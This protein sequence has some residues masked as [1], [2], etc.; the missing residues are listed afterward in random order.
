MKWILWLGLLGG[1]AM[2]QSAQPVAPMPGPVSQGPVAVPPQ[3]AD[4]NAP[5]AL[6]PIPQPPGPATDV[7][8]PAAVAELRL[9]NK[10]DSHP[11]T[12]MLKLGQSVS[13]GS[14]TITLRACLSRPVD[15][16]QDWAAY[17][18]IID[19]HQDES[20]FHGWTLANEPWIGLFEHPVYDV[21]LM[22]CH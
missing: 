3:S 10:V 14:L 13:Y 17:L 15:Q 9:M 20:G 19:S 6:P 5:P 7:W 12:V 18:D 16:I 2:A 8:Q 1:W 21:R 22:R 11:Q 4:A